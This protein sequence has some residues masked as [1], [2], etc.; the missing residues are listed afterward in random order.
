M[1]PQLNRFT[2]KLVE[3][4]AQMAALSSVLTSSVMEVSR[5][6]VKLEETVGDLKKTQEK[7]DT[8]LLA[9]T[10]S[11]LND[12]SVVCPCDKH[13]VKRR[14]VCTATLDTF[15]ETKTVETNPVN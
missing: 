10:H 13:D 12:E 5:R 4:G 14:R 11:L 2:E 1:D 15:V 7:N 3:L 8:D 6:L 9:L